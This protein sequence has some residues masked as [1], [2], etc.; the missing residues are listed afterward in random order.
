MI[1]ALQGLKGADILIRE[2]L[3]RRIVVSNRLL[4]H[5][6][7]NECLAALELLRRDTR[8][9]GARNP[10]GRVIRYLRAC[11]SLLLNYAA[12]RRNDQP[13]SSA[14]AESAV[15]FVVGQRIKRN[16]HMRWTPRLSAPTPFCRCVVQC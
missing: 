8:W 11:A 5:G 7:Q 15:D 1:K 6:R 13:I 2:E 10:L 9:V 3:Q 16:G 14:G 4:L 12:R